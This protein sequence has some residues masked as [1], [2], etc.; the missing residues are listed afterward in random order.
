MKA[1]LLIDFGSTYTKIT[2]VDLDSSS[3]LGNATAF[4]TAGTDIMYGLLAA[5]E[6]LFKLTGE[7]EF[8]QTLACSSA[9]GGLRMVVSGLMPEL[10]AE[11]A[12]GAALG[13]GAKVV[14]AYAHELTSEDLKEI[15]KAEPEIILLTG[16]TDGGNQ[17]VVI[18]NAHRLAGSNLTCPLIYAGNRTAAEELG[19]ILAKFD[20]TVCP[21][22]M[23]RLGELNISPVQEK[24]RQLFMQ[25]IVR[26]KGLSQIESLLTEIVMP[27]PQAM[28][29]AMSL[30]ARGSGNIKGIGDLVAI[31][32]G[33]ATTDVYSLADG[34]PAALN[35]IQKG[36]PEPYAKRTVEGDIG[37]RYGLDGIVAEAGITRLRQITGLE[38]EKIKDL[39]KTLQFEPE[40]LPEKE[41][42]ATL[43]YGIASLAVEIAS[44]RHAGRLEEIYT[45]LGQTFVQSGKDLRSVD[46]IVATGGALVYSSRIE[47][48]LSHALYNPHE[49]KSLRPKRSDFILDKK[50]LLSAMGV[51][52]VIY[53]DIALKI[54]RKELLNE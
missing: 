25:R 48:I 11:A 3:L 42:I 24:I 1:V 4:T 9:A 38:E 47:E 34:F 50:Y 28:L 10:T 27:T 13:A 33:G 14:K 37:M 40:I 16:G 8:V 45:P 17:S 41:E 35:T 2:A 51:L 52:S 43:E 36:L 49:G 6:K 46:K 23:P 29:K 26:A 21:N 30:L 19:K 12:R 15:T 31:D 53:P 22:V 20:L 32:L 54:M 5:Q 7:L 39:L 18:H 44:R